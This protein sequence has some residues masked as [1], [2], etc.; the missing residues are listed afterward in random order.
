[1]EKKKRQV[2]VKP[3]KSLSLDQ[4][5]DAMVECIKCKEI[6]KIYLMSQRFS[7][8]KD[9]AAFK[10]KRAEIE[11]SKQQDNAAANE[12]LQI[13]FVDSNTDDEKKRV[14][15]LESNVRESRGVK[16]DA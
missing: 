14:E 5:E 7:M 13:V 10:L 12:P 16:E 8:L 2:I 3:K 15:K 9:L 11:A 4:I 6:S 1:M